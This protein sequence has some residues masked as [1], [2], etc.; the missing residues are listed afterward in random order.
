M[1]KLINGIS[2]GKDNLKK[3]KHLRSMCKKYKGIELRDEVI[4][5]YKVT[6]NIASAMIKNSRKSKA[7]KSHYYGIFIYN[8]GQMQFVMYVLG[9]DFD[10]MP[11]VTSESVPS[12]Y[13]NQ[14]EVKKVLEDSKKNPLK[15]AI[16][17]TVVVG[18]N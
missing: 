12:K 8:K 13:R 5:K 6:K 14:K 17:K 18:S 15:Y 1:S 10:F 3:L 7:A 2:L 4:K 9:W 11:Y 16:G